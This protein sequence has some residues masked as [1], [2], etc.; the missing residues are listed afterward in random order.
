M[1][2]PADA[3]IFEAFPRLR[4]TLPWLPLGDWPSPLER[5][6]VTWPGGA[7]REIL[8][9]R[10]DLSAP[11]YAGNKIRP[12]ELVFGAAR[13]AG[14]REIWSTGA[15]G[16]NHALAAAVHARRQGFAG[17]AVLW[18]QPWSQTAAENLVATASVADELRFVGSV[19]AMPA[20]A[21]RVRATRSAWVMPPGAAT[22]LGAMGHAG[23]ALELGVQLEARGVRRIDALVLPV[24]STCTTVGM[25]VGTALAQALGL[26]AARPRVVAVRVTPWPVTAPWRIANLAAR[27][28]HALMERMRAAGI[29]PPALPLS[30]RDYLGHLEVIGDE[31]GPGYGH[32]TPAAWG[33][34]AAFA[35]AGI[36]LDTTYSAKA[37][38]HLAKRRDPGP[39]VFWST[40]SQLPLPEALPER[41]AAMPPEAR[42]W[43]A[44]GKLRDI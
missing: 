30:R 28:A 39:V 31:L 25:L 11:G 42:R 12:L 8:V 32:P 15:Y 1:P 17:G 13:E 27:T 35:H 22:P 2:A 33:A 34:V 29:S 36:R 44:R 5:H 20:M 41:V 21:L 23:A 19:V 14:L 38:A 37:A 24:G 10:E 3:A 26:L 18:P 6:L 9:K 4:A 43:L 40:K 16:S 7:A